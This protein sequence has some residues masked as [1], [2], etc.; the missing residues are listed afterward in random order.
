[1]GKEMRKMPK[2]QVTLA[3]IANACGTSSVTVS[4]AL[5]GKDGVSE[6]LRERIRD[7]ARTMGYIPRMGRQSELIGNIGV[8]IPDKFLTSIGTFYWMLFNTIVQ[9]LKQENLSCIQEN[10]G[11]DEE[12]NLSVPNIL[13]N[14]RISG[15][16]S[17]GQLSPEY[18][19]MLRK[20][21]DNIV[22]LDYHL[23]EADIDSVISDGFGGGY[24]LTSHLIQCGHKD[25]GF[26]GNRLATSSIFDRYMGFVRAM[27]EH[28]LT[29]RE[30]WILDDRRRD[31]NNF[32]IIEYPSSMPTAFVCNCDEIAYKVVKDLKN[33]G[34]SVPEDISVAGYDNYVFSQMSEPP[35]TT[36]DVDTH[37]MA[38]KAV[39]LLIER[40]CGIR[41]GHEIITISGELILKG[42][43][44]NILIH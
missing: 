32:G 8:I 4:K 41:S 7:A 19:E 21:T 3:D 40:I 31:N 10:I 22:L 6:E 38:D 30:E 13:A 2:K 12:T 5:S 20:H 9:R 37:K 29:V 43:V 39:Q 28:G 1:M 14:D 25:I 26:I 35:I 18:V 33:L 34:Y 24:K 36:I 44:K 42:S 23:P 16:I 27:L 11:S 15:L 17:L